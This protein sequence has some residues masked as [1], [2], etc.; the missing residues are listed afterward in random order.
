M[1]VGKDAIGA[2]VT[3]GTDG[4]WGKTTHCTNIFGKAKGGG[5]YAEQISS[6]VFKESLGIDRTG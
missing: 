4:L 6:S 2:D 5:I 3:L 1:L